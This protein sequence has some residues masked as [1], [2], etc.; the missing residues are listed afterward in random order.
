MAAADAKRQRVFDFSVWD[1]DRF[2][3]L[4]AELL[5]FVILP[6]RAPETPTLLGETKRLLDKMEALVGTWAHPP[7]PIQ[8]S[9]LCVVGL[10]LDSPVWDTRSD[11]MMAKFVGLFAMNEL[12]AH[13]DACYKYSNGAWLLCKAIPQHLVMELETV[14]AV[15]KCLFKMLHE[16]G[17]N[18]MWDDVFELLN[19]TDWNLLTSVDD[20]DLNIKNWAAKAGQAL[21][22]LPH[23]FTSVDSAAR[24]DLFGEASSQSSYRN[25]SLVEHAI[26]IA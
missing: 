11:F 4:R 8:F 19:F 5:N 21:A 16:A 18:R 3:D 13:P 20:F 26:G 14:V 1:D 24:T 17:T 7:T 25:G 9:S 12:R 6:D 2:K 10:Y 15:S 22:Y 23:R